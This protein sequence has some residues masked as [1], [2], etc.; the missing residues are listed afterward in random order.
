MKPAELSPLKRALLAIEELQAELAAAKKQRHEPIAI[1][2]VGCRIPG[3][4]N[5]P[6][7]F[8][9]LL[10]QGQSGIREIPSDR[11][12]VD[13]YYDPNPDSPGKIAT[14]FG[15]FLEQVDRFEP[16]FFE[17]SPREALTMDPQQRLLLEVAW[18]ALENAGQSPADLAK[19]KTGVYVGV[20]S[21]DYSQLLLESSDPALLDMYYASGIAHSIASGRLSYTLGLQGPSISIDTACSSSLVAVHLACQGLRDQQCD[22]ALAGGVNVILSPKVF[23]ALS[24]A[25]MLAPDGKCK[26]FDAAADGFVRGEGCGVVILKRLRDALADR[27]RIL[28]VIRGSAVN[29]DGPSSGLTAPNGPSQEA[30]LRDALENAQVNPRDVSYIEAHGTG[31][32]LGDPIEVQA[33]GTVFGAGRDPGTPLLIGSLKTNVGHLEAAAGV[34]GLIKVALSLVH[35]E[36]PQHLNFKEPSPHIPWQKLPVK[37]V[38]ERQFWNPV[39]G[40]RIAGVS[41]FGFSG[42]NAHVLLEEAPSAVSETSNPDRPLHLLT[43]SARTEPALRTLVER[44]AERMQAA[45]P[46]EFS[47]LCYT[48]NTGRSHF[49]HRLAVLGADGQT[50]AAVLRANLSDPVTPGLV[51]GSWDGI[52][53]PKIAFLFTGQGAQYPGMGKRLY[54]TSPTFARALDRCAVALRP[55]LDRSLLDLLFPAAE[56][57]SQLDQTRFTQ[58]ALFALEYALNE[59]WRSWGVQPAYVLGHSV[60]E[61]VAACVAGVFSLEDGLTLIAERARLMQAQP[62]G[63]KMVAV[64]APADIIRQ[65]LPGRVSIAALNAPD[66]TVISG[67]GEEIDLV[68]T[69]LKS[70]AIVFRHL[71]VSHAFHSPLMDPVVEPFAQAAAKVSFGT[72]RLRLVSN[73]TGRIATAPEIGQPG[74]WARHLREP[75][76]FTDSVRTLADA[77]CT[78]F[79]E[80]GPSP[81]LISLGRRCTEIEGAHWLPSLR[82]GSDDW[83]QMFASLSELY[84]NGVAVDWSGFDRDYSRR[85]LTLPTYPFQRE[86]Y[87]V[88]RSTKKP[89]RT[90]TAAKLHP[91]A[92]RRISSPSLKD[93]VFESEISAT[94]HPFLE[95]HRLFGRIVF[96]GTAYVET[97]RAAAGLGLEKNSWAI[98]NLVIGQALALEDSETKRLQV[99]LSRN[100]DGTTRFEVFS[101]RVTAIGAEDTWQLHASGNLVAREKPTSAT[102]DLDAFRH[103]AEELGSERFYAS[104]QRRGVDFGPRFRGVT[105]LWRRPGQALGLIEAPLLLGC[106]VNEYA[107]HPAL[108]DA[109]IQVVAGAV[110]EVDADPELFMPLGIESI[111]VFEAPAGKLWSLA[112]IEGDSSNQE[113]VRARFQIADECGRLVAEIRGMSFKR[114]QR[115]ALERAIQRNVDGSL[116]ETVW[117]PLVVSE[118]AASESMATK[119]SAEL[120]SNPENSV[121]RQPSLLPTARPRRWLILGDRA[122]T[123]QKL[124]DFL[125]ARGDEPV[126][127]SVQDGAIID[128]SEADKNL[129]SARQSGFDRL[130]DRYFRRD[131]APLDG[132]IYL[133]PLDAS[134][135][136][137]AATGCEHETEFYCGAALQLVQALVRHAETQPPRLWLCTRG[138]HKADPADRAFSPAGAALWGLGKV[139]GLEHP[140]FRCVRLDLDP[141]GTDAIESLAAILD[142]EPGENEIAIRSGRQL[143]PR[144]QRLRKAVHPTTDP[145]TRLAGRP[146]ELSFSNRGSLENLKLELRERRSPAAGEVEIRVYATALNFRDVMNVMGLYP[147]D[148]GPLGA[149]F[150]GEIVA[151]GHGVTKFALGDKVVGLAPGSFGAYVTTP[152]ALVAP[153]PARVSFD[154]AVTLPVAYITAYFTLCHLGKLQPEDTVLIHAAAGGVGFAAVT[155]AK[156]A[157]AKIF[158]TAGSPEKRALLKSMGVAHVLDSRSLDFAAQI[159]DLTNGRG[160]DVV[161]NSLADQF[162]DHSFQVIAQ[163]GRFLEIGKR[164]IWEPERVAGLGRGIQYHIVDWS[165]EAQENP[166]LI[167]S[168]LRDLVAA[169]DRD[170][171]DPLPHRVFSLRDAEAAFR[172][173]AQGRHTGK[174]VVSHAQTLGPETTFSLDAD[175]TYLITGGFRGVGLM[176][177]QWLADRGARHL[178]LTGR[179]TPELSNS[180]FQAIQARGVQLR[181]VQADI[182]DEKAMRRVLEDLRET[183]PPLRGVIHSAGVLDDG[184]LLQQSW[185]RFTTVFAPKVAGSLV[186]HRLTASDPLDFCVFFSSIASVFGSP[187]QSSYAAANAF[188]NGLA[189]ARNAAGKPSV[190]INWGA[191]AGAGMAVDRGLISRARESGFG[192]LEPG[193][194]FQALEVALMAGRSQ[195]MISPVDWPTFLRHSQPGGYSLAFLNDFIQPASSV[196]QRSNDQ[197]EAVDVRTERGVSKSAAFR[198]RLDAVAP[199]RRRSV[200]LEQIR[201]EV[202]HVLGLQNSGSLPNNKPLHEFGLDSLMAV[203]LRNR[204]GDV[205]GHSLPA[206]LLFDY[207]TVDG[208]T[209]YLSR[210]ALKLEETQSPKQ[211][212]ATSA[213][214]DVLSQIENLDDAEIDRLFE[215]KG[216]G[217]IASE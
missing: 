8:W 61:Y 197:S 45:G 47:D 59:L 38:G 14:R 206:T 107:V 185:E 134:V 29:Q 56:A 41:S 46:G 122:G 4:A 129:G 19:T 207:P 142:A 126:L 16:Q 70:E 75:V 119:R 136:N 173:M 115:A 64:M 124:A 82:R 51:R 214:L 15:G 130:V 74:Y 35:Q 17:I 203:E 99:V 83:A 121:R 201:N 96:P 139:I 174:V 27:D 145:I 3:G 21:S 24:R 141:S 188:L 117:A 199:N 77:G 97:V 133:W 157:G 166:E 212:A 49:Q 22:L 91:L 146:Y 53:R 6:D 33:L 101:S 12:D 79:V 54:E 176:A 202:A 125:A 86:R 156:R 111:R 113:T 158:A 184:I 78:L 175:G 9:Q 152:A 217:S 48:S 31:T 128:R 183:M 168:M 42:T 43:I 163:N 72:P 169:V 2:G 36:L 138:A 108:L 193:A 177:A 63:G 106:E 32:S 165:V 149:E 69:K 20:C 76:Q 65:F 179:Q 118:T 180:T 167:G 171:L 154:A 211:P 162:V 132:V 103:E 116:Y 159:L 196:D 198:Q 216:I 37:V 131:D 150:A 148:A 213:G 18:E 50:A 39:N 80:I 140:E 109:C 95:D 137:L 71:P 127:A 88:E 187:G 170:E 144:L 110:D 195:V 112:S 194:G 204:L 153:K 52:D 164:G 87:F 30:V 81:T 189:Q 34:S 58:P 215:S 26:T 13:A 10:H 68:T 135:D 1:V 73:L 161:L 120:V 93:L 94:S 66:Q 186:L 172:F 178:V 44:Y 191:W 123:G 160:V 182:S 92:A 5:S 100:Q 102:I 114:A 143:G 190:S 155:L 210:N 57:G 208:L 205:V 55:Y 85:R 209:E 192:V 28:A 62:A 104:Y 40:T 200:V 181:C 151:L 147:G 98:E 11:W 23:S 90:E 60:G 7:Q 89:I 67:A 105:R 25:R 84:V